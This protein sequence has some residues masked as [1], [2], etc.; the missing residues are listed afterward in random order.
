[1]A[2]LFGLASQIKAGNLPK[3]KGEAPANMS[4]SRDAD[5]G[6]AKRSHLMQDTCWC[7]SSRLSSVI[8]YR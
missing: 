6:K 1:M 3:L 2:V 4:M 7:W 8:I 5:P